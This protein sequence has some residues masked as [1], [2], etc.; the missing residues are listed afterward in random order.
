VKTNDFIS[1]L[2]ED[3]PVRWRF[4]RV[5]ALAIIG[6]IL[7]AGTLF[8]AGVHPRPDIGHAAET[9][10]FLFK[11]V[12]TLTLAVTAGGLAL[13][14]ARPGVPT[15]FWRWAPMAAPILLVV[16][17]IAE[18]SV[19]PSSTWETR[20]IGH[21]SIACMTLIPLMA[22]GPLICLILALRQGAPKRPGATGALAGL[23]ATGIAATFYASHC[24]DDSPLFVATWYPIATGIVVLC[25]YLAGKRFLRW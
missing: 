17:V 6:G 12:V 3:T 11:F 18:L 20:W 24:P 23:I 13:R 22:I 10:R 2:A 4:G 1:A 7:S 14:L 15:G 19:M 8:L 21:N 9:I 16:A 5:F 25:G